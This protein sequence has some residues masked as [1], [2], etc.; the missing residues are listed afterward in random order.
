MRT[1]Q[2]HPASLLSGIGLA[3]LAMLA[4]GQSPQP[5]TPTLSPRN[6]PLAVIQARDFVQIRQGQPYTVPTGKILV[7][8]ALGTEQDFSGAILT[9][10]N[11]TRVRTVFANGTTGS[12]VV[13]V[14][15]GLTMAA[16]EVVEVINNNPQYPTAA[17]WGY[18]GDA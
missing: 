12:S 7:I 13:E 8:T 3:C 18:L 15:R 2:L 6:Q 16:G 10:N 5:A 17:A 14:P 9:V 11:T 1:I 4:M